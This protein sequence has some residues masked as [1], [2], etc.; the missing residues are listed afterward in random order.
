MKDKFSVFWNE[1]IKECHGDTDL[2]V[3]AVALL[4][5]RTEDAVA[6]ICERNPHTKED[7]LRREIAEFIK[8]LKPN[9]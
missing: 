7:E 1:A 3:F 4:N 8:T 9:K 6:I 5:K 2:A